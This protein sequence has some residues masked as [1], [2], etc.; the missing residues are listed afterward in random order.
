MSVSFKRCTNLE[1]WGGGET[2]DGSDPIAGLEFMGTYLR[3]RC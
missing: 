3:S 1:T 2:P